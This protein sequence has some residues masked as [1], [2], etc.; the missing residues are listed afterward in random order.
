MMILKN[1][2]FLVA[3]T[4]LTTLATAKTI[5]TKNAF[6][7]KLEIESAREHSCPGQYDLVSESLYGIHAATRLVTGI[8]V[9]HDTRRAEARQ[10]LVTQLVASTDKETA[11]AIEKAFNDLNRQ[12]DY[13]CLSFGKSTGEILLSIEAFS[14]NESIELKIPANTVIK[15]ITYLTVL[16]SENDQ[17]EDDHQA[18]AEYSIE[19]GGQ[20]DTVFGSKLTLYK[21]ANQPKCLGCVSLAA[22]YDGNKVGVGSTLVSRVKYTSDDA[23]CELTHGDSRLETLNSESPESAVELM[24]VLR[25]AGNKAKCLKSKLKIELQAKKCMNPTVK[26][27]RLFETR[28][29][30]EIPLQD[31]LKLKESTQP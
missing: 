9:K 18:R 8:E 28:E 1:S 30:Y 19:L 20:G 24:T 31:V 21:P 2:T 13:N 26:H 10:E 29:E 5:P 14:G 12:P 25:L 4:V 17:N 16:S 15:K 22:I 3:A 7:L 23:L 11:D 6:A 27:C